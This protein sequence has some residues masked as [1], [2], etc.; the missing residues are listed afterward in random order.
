MASIGDGAP[1]AGGNG[2]APGGGGNGGAPG[3]N[4]NEGNTNASTSSAPFSGYMVLSLIDVLLVIYILIMLSL[5]LQSY[6]NVDDAYAYV[7]KSMPIFLFS[8]TT[9]LLTIVN[10]MFIILLF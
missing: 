6:V 3:D 8:H 7:M 5:G 1:G 10:V 4:T 9:R 2:S